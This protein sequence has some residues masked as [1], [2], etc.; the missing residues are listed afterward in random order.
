MKAGPPARVEQSRD[1]IWSVRMSGQ[2]GVK[3][4]LS[5][6]F[7][8]T[9]D[10]CRGG[11]H[12]SGRERMRVTARPPNSNH[13]PATAGLAPGRGRWSFGLTRAGVATRKIVCA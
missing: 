3:L 9:C 4:E 1:A 12:H 5:R 2:R 10:E 13:L 8:E 7:D 6:D 11:W